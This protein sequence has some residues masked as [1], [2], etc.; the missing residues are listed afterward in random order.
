[1]HTLPQ[2]IEVWYIIPVIRRE[3]AMCFSREHKISYDNIA[4]MMG[5]SKAAIS[6]YIAGKRVE[7]IKMHPKALEEVKISCNK[8]VKNK[9]TVIREISRVL[10]IIKKKKLHCELCGEMIDGELHD[11]KEIKIPE[12]VI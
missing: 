1:M 9:S 8:I 10:E 5:L 6:Q 12:A 11:C 2:E 7:R 3:M 4:S